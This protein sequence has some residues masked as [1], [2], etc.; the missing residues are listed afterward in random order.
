[1]KLTQTQENDLL[2]RGVSRRS[3]GQIAS[4]IAAGASSLPLFSEMAY[5][6]AARLRE[7]IPAGAVLINANENPMGPSKEGLDRKPPENSGGTGRREE[8][9]RS[10]HLRF[11][12][13]SAPEHTGLHFSDE[14]ARYG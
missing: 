10:D 6:Q 14:V 5:A 7:P 13:A 2:S 8:R 3:F 1:L 11:Q 12:P 9:L 4:L